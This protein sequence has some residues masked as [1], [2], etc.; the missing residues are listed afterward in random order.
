MICKKCGGTV[1]IRSEVYIRDVAC[2]CSYE[3]E[4]CGSVDPK[5]VEEEDDD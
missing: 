4:N 2:V 3:C 1:T 5:D